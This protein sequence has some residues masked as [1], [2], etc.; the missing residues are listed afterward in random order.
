M[1]MN[2][3]AAAY[4][5]GHAARTG[6]PT[7][8]AELVS[9]Q[10]DALSDEELERLVVAGRE[11]GLQLYR[12]KNHAELPRVHWALSFL[13]SV[14]PESLLD[15][16]SGRGVFLLPFLCRFPG[17]PVTSVDLLDY[18]TAFLHDIHAGGVE[19]LT[20]LQAD[21]CTAALPENGFD[22]VTLLEVLEHIPDVEAAIRQAVRLARRYVV[23]TVPSKPDDNPG[24]IHLLTRA[25]LTDL[26]TRAGCS[27]LQFDGVPGHLTLIA[28]VGQPSKHTEE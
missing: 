5:R 3:L 17:V 2:R 24:H 10:L 8:P 21:I 19:Q 18:R 20:A 25:Q 23:V 9:A 7:L 16:G 22:V 27:R 12:F 1:E 4:I 11:A 15:V 26:F 13:R 6:S 14:W 28:S